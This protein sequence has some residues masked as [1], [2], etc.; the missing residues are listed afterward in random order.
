MQ[1]DPFNQKPKITRQEQGALDR[2]RSGERKRISGRVVDLFHGQSKGV[3]ASAVKPAED[4]VFRGTCGTCRNGRHFVMREGV[5]LPIAW[6]SSVTPPAAGDWIQ[7]QVKV[8]KWR[9]RSESSPCELNPVQYEP[10]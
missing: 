4:V 9:Y 2:A 10:I 7:C 6:P 8:E 5:A 3:E 1:S